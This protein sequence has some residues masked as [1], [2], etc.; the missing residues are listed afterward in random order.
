MPSRSTVKQLEFLSRSG[1][2]YGI[3]FGQSGY[4]QR[5]L[6]SQSLGALAA[7]RGGVGC[8]PH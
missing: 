1:G 6:G 7:A 2:V 5:P 4:Y 3:N 8:A